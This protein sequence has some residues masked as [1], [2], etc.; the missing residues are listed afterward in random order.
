L[1]PSAFIDRQAWM[2]RWRFS[3]WA[4]DNMAAPAPSAHDPPQA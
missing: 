2:M 3:F 4:A 1:M